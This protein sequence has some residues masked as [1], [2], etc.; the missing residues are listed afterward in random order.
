MASGVVR[1][2]MAYYKYNCLIINGYEGVP[3]FAVGE[4]DR[5]GQSITRCQCVFILFRFQVKA[6]SALAASSASQRTALYDMKNVFTM[7]DA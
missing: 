4:N 3:E 1:G 2:K 5:K 7:Q 6:L